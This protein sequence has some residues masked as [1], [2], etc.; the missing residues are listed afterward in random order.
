M[1][2]RQQDAV[3]EPQDQFA[4]PSG[5]VQ[6]FKLGAA[7]VSP[8]LGQPFAGQDNTRPNRHRGEKTVQFREVH[9]VLGHGIG[10]QEVIELVDFS[11]AERFL[12]QHG[13]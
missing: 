12:D 10:R 4:D 2:E 11:L 13:A 6:G 3:I 5:V 8:D 9:A 7:F 1:F